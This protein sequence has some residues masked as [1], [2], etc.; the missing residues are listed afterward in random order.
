MSTRTRR[1]SRYTIDKTRLLLVIIVI[2][3]LLIVRSL[4]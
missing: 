4:Y 3:L 1:R 2:L